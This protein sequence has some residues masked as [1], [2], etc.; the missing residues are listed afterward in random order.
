[1]SVEE[2]LPRFLSQSFEPRPYVFHVLHQG[3]F[4]EFKGLGNLANQLRVWLRTRGVTDQ[5][6]QF[7][8]L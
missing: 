1:M 3:S 8:L 7:I 2:R 4:P 5:G 6:N